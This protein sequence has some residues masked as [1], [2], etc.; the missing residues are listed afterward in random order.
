MGRTQQGELTSTG[1]GQLPPVPLQVWESLSL[2]HLSLSLPTTLESFVHLTSPRLW[3][4]VHLPGS[5][6]SGICLAGA[7]SMLADYMHTK[8]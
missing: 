3:V 8:P 1:S 6:L 4:P 7:W 5:L 2:A